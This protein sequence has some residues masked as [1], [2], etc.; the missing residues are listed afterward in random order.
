MWKLKEA[1]QGF[2]YL[3]KA[4]ERAHANFQLFTNFV[5]PFPIL[6]DLVGNFNFHDFI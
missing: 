5:Q 6:T 2:W 1:T 3:I 4:A